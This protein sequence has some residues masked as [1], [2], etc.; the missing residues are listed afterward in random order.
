[1]NLWRPLIGKEIQEDFRSARGA[2]FLVVAALVLSVFAVLL[3]S[4]TE[5]SLLDNAQA[6]YMMAGIVIAL[7]ALVAVLRGSDG[8]AGERDRQ[9]LEPLLLAPING[10]GLAA[11]KLCGILVSWLTLF[12]LAIP[13][14]WAVGSTG[15]NLFAAI[16]YLFLAGTLIVLVFGGAALA[17]SARMKTFKGVLSLGLTVLLLL[18]SP[19][20]LGPSLRQSAVGRVLD[21]VNPFAA[22][23]N[24]LDSVIIDS[25]GLSW[26]LLRLAVMGSYGLAV[27]WWLYAATR[28]L[29]P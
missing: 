8:F 21:L 18:G 19:V 3:V 14:L 1:M 10:S 9:T 13:Y 15:Q 4:N 22:A 27:L 26:Q 17:L 29:E 25:Q 28:R 11:A 5:L 7:A 16:L 23:L 6:V 24:T 12:I 2:F 20:L